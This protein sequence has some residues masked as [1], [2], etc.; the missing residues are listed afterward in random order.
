[1]LL[2]VR[3]VA[4]VFRSVVI[5][6]AT[7]FAFAD[8]SAAPGQRVVAPPTSQAEPTTQAVPTTVDALAGLPLG[9]ARCQP[10]SPVANTVYGHETRGTAAGLQLY[11]LIF[12]N[13]Q[14][15]HDVKIVW[16][17]TGS[18]DL[19][20]TAIAPDRRAAPLVF[21][22]TLHSSSTYQ[23]PGEEWGVGYHFSE[24]G[25]WDLHFVRGHT[26]ADA[27]FSIRA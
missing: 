6:A 18:G 22:P 9:R 26:P 20:A 10:P 7:V 11:G 19:T 27:W 14:R 1:M 3:R 15:G 12:G 2:A 8:C 4:P 16:R 21:G 23:R 17:I 13:L 5:V 24:A 25:C